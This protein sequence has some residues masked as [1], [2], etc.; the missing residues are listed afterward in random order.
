MQ[1]AESCRREL[2]CREELRIELERLGCSFAG[3]VETIGRQKD[4]TDWAAIRFEN[5]RGGRF[6]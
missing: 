2:S 1:L 6:S 3:N 5:A 4:A